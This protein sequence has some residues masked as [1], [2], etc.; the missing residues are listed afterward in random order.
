MGFVSLLVTTEVLL[1]IV[2]LTE[3]KVTITSL[4]VSFMTMMYLFSEHFFEETELKDF[5]L[6][7]F[8]G[9]M[10]SV[11]ALSVFKE[12]GIEKHSSSLLIGLTVGIYSYIKITNNSQKIKNNFAIKKDPLS[13]FFDNMTSVLFKEQAD[14]TIIYYAKGLLR[15]GYIITDE[16]KKEKLYTFHNRVFKYLLPLGIIYALFLGL[17]GVPFLGLI[18]IFLVAFILH[19]KQK[20]LIQ[21]LPIYEEKLT[22]KESK[23]TIA[24][25]FPKWFTIFMIINGVVGILLT[26]S[27]PTLLQKSIEELSTLMM[28]TFT[29]GILLLVMGL[30]LYRAKQNS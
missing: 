10:A 26:I 12:L 23:K 19:F 7:F 15:K 11:I 8:I 13:G 17:L 2:K 25:T 28:M 22:F 3:S 6:S 1:N 20:N 14:G 5:L 21:G 27:L 29:M 9:F 30:Y 16:V 18:P 4:V 24:N